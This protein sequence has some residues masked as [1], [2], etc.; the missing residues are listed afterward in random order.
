MYVS[1]YKDLVNHFLEQ[2]RHFAF[3][4]ATYENSS[5]SASSPAPDAV[6]LLAV[7][8]GA[9]SCLTMILMCISLMTDDAMG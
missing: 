1:L 3:L 8:T 7:L 6:V 5:C 2:W 4:A 9:Y